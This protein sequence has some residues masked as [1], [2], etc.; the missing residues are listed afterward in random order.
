MAFHV[1][2]VSPGP[3][4]RDRARAIAAG[5]LHVSAEASYP[6]LL[7]LAGFRRIDEVDLTHEYRVT[8]AAWLHESARVAE[9]LE[10]VFGIEEFRRRQAE[11]KDTLAAIDGGLLRRSLFAARAS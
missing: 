11:R 8:A 2:F 5:P 10:E 4:E 7:T 9:Q 1:I 3:S 6:E